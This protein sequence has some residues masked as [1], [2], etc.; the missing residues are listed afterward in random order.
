LAAVV[1]DG[2]AQMRRFSRCYGPVKLSTAG[3]DLSIATERF[4]IW[5]GGGGLVSRTFFSHLLQPQQ[6]KIIFLDKIG[7]IVVVMHQKTW[8]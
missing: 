3:V 5:K 7:T 4:G 2:V 6:L 1:G 8:A